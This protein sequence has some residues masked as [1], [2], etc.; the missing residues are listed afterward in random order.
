MLSVFLISSCLS[1]KLHY[2]AMD[3]TATNNMLEGAEIQGNTTDQSAQC[4]KFGCASFP[5]PWLNV[6]CQFCTT[7]ARCKPIWGKSKKGKSKC[8]SIGS[9]QLKSEELCKSGLPKDGEYATAAIAA[10]I[11]LYMMTSTDITKAKRLCVEK[12]P[13]FPQ[14]TCIVERFA[15]LPCED[16]PDKAACKKTRD[17]EV[18]MCDDDLAMRCRS[19]CGCDGIFR[20]VFVWKFDNGWKRKEI[21]KESYTDCFDKDKLKKLSGYAIVP[22]TRVNTLMVGKDIRS[23]WNSKLTPGPTVATSWSIQNFASP[24]SVEMSYATLVSLDS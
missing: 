6:C 12:T 11:K 16:K 20:K 14:F 2:D 21:L 17:A 7:H 22:H 4:F 10:K 3:S 1:L 15:E 8:T 19:A 23:C 24:K 5:N 18:G 13:K 9:I